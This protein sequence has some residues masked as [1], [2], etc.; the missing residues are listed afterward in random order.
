MGRTQRNLCR[1]SSVSII[2]LATDFQLYSGSTRKETRSHFFFSKL[3]V[4]VNNF[5]NVCL[6][7]SLVFVHRFQQSLCFSNG[8]FIV[9]LGDVMYTLRFRGP[10]KYQFIRKANVTLWWC[11]FLSWIMVIYNFIVGNVEKL[12][13]QEDDCINFVEL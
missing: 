8:E 13:K 11:L 3:P 10:V 5:H 9:R 12:N 1:N 7:A 4:V 6:K 2:L